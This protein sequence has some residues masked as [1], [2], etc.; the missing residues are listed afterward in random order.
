M[1]RQQRLDNIAVEIE[2]CT[3]CKKDSLG[4]AVPGE[5][6]AH[7][8]AMFIGEAP[9]KQE[10]ASGRPF[11]GRSGQLLRKT[12]R[13]IGLSGEDIF[14]TSVCK[15]LPK[16]GTP[17]PAQ[18]RYGR[19]HLYEQIAVISPRLLVLLGRTACLGVLGKPI[20]V[21][22]EHGTVIEKDGIACFIS[23]HPAAAIR[24]KKNLV[25]F[26]EDFKKLKK[27]ITTL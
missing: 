3:F 10:A 14:I 23:Y 12:I 6:N 26:K 18:I 8:K 9:G 19:I 4:K 20:S 1:T 27:I 2:N 17:S 21:V 25:L 22:K 5:G 13:E 16:K 15:Y 11:V 7:A 24:F